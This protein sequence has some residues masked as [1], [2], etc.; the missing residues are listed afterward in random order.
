MSFVLQTD[1]GDEE[2]KKNVDKLMPQKVKKRRK[3]QTED[4]VSVYF[5]SLVYNLLS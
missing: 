5:K 3:I 2:T 4:G 1:N